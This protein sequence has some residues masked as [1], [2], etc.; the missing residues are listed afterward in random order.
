MQNLNIE[1]LPAAGNADPA[2]DEDYVP[3]GYAADITSQ[4][5]K[6]I[7]FRFGSFL[8]RT[9]VEDFKCNLP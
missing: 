4:G 1:Q 2:V 7:P 9:E 3:S 5:N 8:T 6:N